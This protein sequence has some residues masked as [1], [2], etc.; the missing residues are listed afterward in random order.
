MSIRYFHHNPAHNLCAYPNLITSSP[1][2]RE[3]L[4]TQFDLYNAIIPLIQLKPNWRF[5]V[6]PDWTRAIPDAGD[7]KK[8][9]IYGLHIV[10][11]G[12]TLGSIYIDRK[13]SS[14]KLC[15]NNERICAKRERNKPYCT[16]D[17]TK[18]TIAIRKHFYRLGIDERVEK[19]KEAAANLIA[20]EASDKSWKYRSRKGEMLGSAAEFAMTNL[21]A[22]LEAFPKHMAKHEEVKQFSAE[23]DVIT[24]IKTAF[25]NGDAVVV[26][27]DG[28]HYIVRNKEIGRAHV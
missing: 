12:E 5:V 24:E 7:S 9:V 3:K 15:V 4:E 19:A 14:N 25:D 16:E 13:G 8:S 10:E 28:T 6:N 22:Y 1:A 23:L 18:A 17:A 27:F 2:V 11:D 26:V 21:T 20:S